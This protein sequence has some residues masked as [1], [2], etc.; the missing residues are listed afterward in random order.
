MNKTFLLYITPLLLAT[1]PMHYAFSS[2][3]SI[4]AYEHKKVANIK[5]KLENL[6]PGSPFNSEQVLTKLNTKAGDPFSQIT[7]DQDLKTL[8]QEYD[9]TEPSI[10]IKNGEIYITIR[11]WQK[12][13]I[14]QI[15]FIHKK[16]KTH[17]LEHELGIEPN[18]VFNRDEFNRAFNK[19]K[20]FYI[21]KGYFEA[22]LQYT[23]VPIPNKNE[24]NIVIKIE[25]GRSG[26]VQQLKFDGFTPAEESAVLEMIHTKKFN[27]FTSWLT[28][29][30]IYHE[31]ALE[32]DK[33]IIIDYLQNQGFA[34]A[35]VMITT[36]DTESGV[37]ILVQA[38]RGQ[39]FH[40]GEVSFSGNTLFT[41]EEV[42]RV[43]LTKSKGIYSPEKLRR[44]IQEI[45]DLYGNKGYIETDVQ[46]TLQL[47]HAEPIYNLHFQI[48]ENEQF[49]VGMI[50]IL[51]NVQTNT[52]VILHAA[53]ITPGEV[54]DSRRLKA[55]QQHLEAMGY[56]KSVNVY[57]VRSVD[58]TSLGPNY[59]DVIIE[60]DETT[61]GNA[62]L[63]FG[64]SSVDSIYGGLDLAETNFNYKGLSKFW[65]SLSSLRGGGEYAHAR[66]SWGAKESNYS[67]SWMTPYFRDT[68]WRVGFDTSYST[69]K[70]QSKDYDIN[71]LGFAIYA[72]YP[73]TPYLTHGWKFRINN[74][75]I[76]IK[77]SAGAEAREQ[78]KNSGLVAGITG[79][80]NYDSTDNAFK[81]HRG[82]RS[83]FETELAGIR[84][85]SSFQRMFPFLRFAFIN[86]YYYPVWRKGTLKTRFDL[87]YI[88][89]FGGNGDFENIPLSE[90]FFLGGD[91]SVR[92]YKA[93]K[94][95]PKFVKNGQPQPDEPTGG[96]SSFLFSVEYLQNIYKPIDAFVFFDSGSISDKQFDLGSV[97][98]SYGVGLRLELSARSPVI[99]GY[100]FPINPGKDPL[101]RFFF[102]MGGQF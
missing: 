81:P 92:G 48:E 59:R 22:E 62:S 8:S 74:A 41:H 20:E 33:L 82:L 53:L 102:A 49:K 28:G 95:G 14:K 99:V 60:V 68:Q 71:N 4:E 73:F 44:T 39:L 67:I 43:L 96:I 94:I 51:G 101:K 78:E 93:L 27:L 16:F 57:A 47:T 2:Q 25:E 65:K 21:K 97:R 9:R 52:S 86:N 75:I 79:S 55:T 80:I 12:P 37:N 50:R 36:I 32:H 31:E 6:P 91:S 72:N 64:F 19:L 23:V 15:K 3:P 63:F 38:H 35:K 46:Y 7:F 88:Y 69:S 83:V 18:T 77:K 11:I 17:T 40:F 85:H 98:M 56:F 54:F 84:R 34:D 13:I 61:T 90:R 76:D 26:R 66:A 45:K 30:G 29:K 42:S 87:K 24:M 58:D 5:I 70:L 100:A 89:P 1:A 10:E